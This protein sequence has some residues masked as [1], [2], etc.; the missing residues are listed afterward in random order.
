M[1]FV[2]N[3]I[4]YFNLNEFMIFVNLIFI[5]NY[6]FYDWRVKFWFVGVRFRRLFD[7]YV[8]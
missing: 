8:W 3:I 1:F 7:V 2:V 4:D 6:R 5:M